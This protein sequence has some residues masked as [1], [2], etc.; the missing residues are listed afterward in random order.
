MAYV[1]LSRYH[2][3]STENQRIF[4]QALAPGA[5]DSLRFDSGYRV[6]SINRIKVKDGISKSGTIITGAA[7]Q[8]N[9]E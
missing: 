9:P 6:R 4:N 7:N 2:L 1:L 5:K 3:K 8:E